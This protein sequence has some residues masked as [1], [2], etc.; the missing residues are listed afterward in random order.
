[1]WRQRSRQPRYRRCRRSAGHGDVDHENG[2]FRTD[3][4]T[5]ISRGALQYQSS[6]AAEPISTGQAAGLIYRGLSG[7]RLASTDGNERLAVWIPAP[8]LEQRLAA[9]IGEPDK[10]TLSFV[11]RIDWDTAEGQ[12]IQRLTRLLQFGCATY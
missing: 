7:Y 5:T 4:I 3:C 11:L 6:R 2:Y 12:G 1:M 8:A 10:D 9:L